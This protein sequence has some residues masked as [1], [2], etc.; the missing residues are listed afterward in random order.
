V[1]VKPLVPILT[2]TCDLQEKAS[3]MSMTATVRRTARLD[4]RILLASVAAT[5]LVLTASAGAANAAGAESTIVPSAVVPSAV[6]PGSCVPAD[7]FVNS[8]EDPL[9]LQRYGVD[10][11]TGALTLES[12]VALDQPLGDIAWN[13]DESVLYGVDWGDDAQNLVTIDPTTGTSTTV[14]PLRYAD[15]SPQYEGN[16]L[17]SLSATADGT[18]LT[19]GTMY[20]SIFSV[21]P[22][23]GIITDSPLSFPTLADGTSY[24]ASSGDFLTLDDGR[25]LGVAYDGN[26]N[27]FLVLFD[28]EAGTSTVVGQVPFSVGA[29]LSGGRVYLAAGDGQILSLDAL[30][31]T[32]SEEMLATTVQATTGLPLY[33]A[34]SRQ[35]SGECPIAALGFSK[36]Y[37]GND[38][39]DRSGSVTLGDT[40]SY[41]LTATNTG[42]SDLSDVVVTDA[43]AGQSTTCATLAPGSVCALTATL[44]VTQA[45][46]DARQVVNTG[47]ALSAETALVD[48]TVTTA[49]TP[50][51]SAAIAPAPTAPDAGGQLAKTGSESAPAAIPAATALFLVGALLLAIRRRRA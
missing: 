15:G 3:E 24:L 21:D 50:S 18:L 14:G 26:G 29:A 30:P 2:T 34:T 23:T 10:A 22:A 49:V 51:Q 46:V 32:P 36:T 37:T 8:G 43:R 19:S 41:E 40:L 35:D 44:R 33:G 5:A 6:A 25:I 48:D 16:W 39:A 31:L 11:A 17:N 1:S 13:A 9:T 38:D 4:W 47:T 28:F 45:D 7:V 20:T 42:T 27:S 12:E